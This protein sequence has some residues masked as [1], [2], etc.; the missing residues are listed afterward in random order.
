VRV[1]VLN[2]GSSTL[3]ASVLDTPEREPRFTGTVRTSADT[4]DATWRSGVGELLAGASEAGVESAT[5]EAVGH[6]VVH[7]GTEFR[8]P[9]LV[10][11]AVARAID[12]LAD[13]APLHNPA[14]AATL[15]A[16]RDVLPGVPHVAAFDTAFHGSLPEAAY[17][18]PVP[19][20]WYRDLG[21]RRFGFHGISVAWSVR[22]TAEL[23]DRPPADLRLVVAHLGSGCSV[24][25]VD[26]GR[27]VDTSMG[28]TPLEGLMMGTRAGSIDPGIVFRL[29]RHGVA[30]DAIEDDLEHRSGLVGVAGTQ[31]V[32]ELL[33]REAAGDA[34]ASLA[35][36]LFVRR[37][38]AAIAGAATTLP[39]LDALVF[40][41]GVGENAASIRR[42]ICERL[43]GLG[44]PTPEDVDVARADASR[45]HA[46]PADA[47]ANAHASPADAVLAR[48]P[49]GPS[50]LRIHAREDV[51]IAEAA[52]RLVARQR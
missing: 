13:L 49:D 25:A 4:S 36:E 38:A 31:D 12:G 46:A 15:R 20:R 14:A 48:R 11:A 27:S 30:A 3:K 33:A 16:G 24:T 6:R 44:V 45:A 40:T 9:V 1:L 50:V 37:A 29:L 32:P 19:E 47:S 26:G 34:E 17:R 43:G 10:D 18:Y 35:L 2:A 23:L 51:V 8:H 41:A 52:A 28:L 39:S 7:G 5:I 21:V 22:R 42:R